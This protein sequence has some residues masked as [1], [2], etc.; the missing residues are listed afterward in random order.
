MATSTMTEKLKAK[1]KCNLCHALLFQP[2]T[3]LCQH[4]FC[5]ACLD[6]IL[7]FHNDG[8][9]TLHCPNKCKGIVTVNKTL[10]INN[11]LSSSFELLHVLDM[12]KEETKER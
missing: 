12:L 6:E 3:L 5:N 4:S 7:E 11:A 10:S 9:A 2:K 8:S 1:M